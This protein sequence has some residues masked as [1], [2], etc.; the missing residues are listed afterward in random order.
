MAPSQ[1]SLPNEDIRSFITVI[2]E[3]KSDCLEKRDMSQPET[4]VNIPTLPTSPGNRETFPAEN[5]THST[6]N[7]VAIIQT[8]LL[9]SGNL[10][11]PEEIIPLGHDNVYTSVVESQNNMIQHLQAASEIH[12]SIDSIV[13]ECSKLMPGIEEHNLIQ[14]ACN[15]NQENSVATNDESIKGPN[16]D[17][18][19]HVPFKRL[20]VE[21]TPLIQ[22]NEIIS[23]QQSQSSRDIIKRPIQCDLSSQSSLQCV[24]EEK[25][26]DHLSQNEIVNFQE[27]SSNKDINKI[28]MASELSSLSSSQNEYAKKMTNQ[29]PQSTKGNK[30]STFAEIDSQA[31][32][33]VE[34]SE[35]SK[36]ENRGKTSVEDSGNKEK[37]IDNKQK[38]VG[39]S[40]NKEKVIDK[41]KE[42][43]IDNKQKSFGDSENKEKVI[44]KN[45]ETVIDNKQK[46]FGDSGN[47]EKL[48]DNSQTT[49]GDSGNKE[50]VIDKK[51]V[52]EVNGSK[53]KCADKSKSVKNVQVE[54]KLS[55]KDIGISGQIKVKCVFLAFYFAC[56]SVLIICI[57]SLSYCSCFKLAYIVFCC[58]KM[59][60][61]RVINLLITILLVIRGLPVCNT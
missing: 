61:E 44:D 11:G 57:K 13:S 10:V 52:E 14:T 15:S 26:T 38:S 60:I 3:V 31:V 20:K 59:H 39:D 34:K 33:K 4:T 58:R 1:N 22:G 49:V 43:V 35:G 46:A 24:C 18:S 45:K 53:E 23:W 21:E 48:I 47:K 36:L 27:S 32:N 7:T 17:N 42:K 50:K 37:V 30:N 8:C 54:S 25:I 41:N 28:L 56:L 12:N 16:C 29:S 51:Q 19:Y 6:V 40:V 2:P 9:A 5:E 55:G